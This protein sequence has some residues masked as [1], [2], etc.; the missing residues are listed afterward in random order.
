[1]R[2]DEARR[3]AARLLAGTDPAPAGF[4]WLV[5]AGPGEPDLLT[6]RAQR[7]LGEADVI[8]HDDAIPPALLSLGRRDARR[9]AVAGGAAAETGMLLAR[10]A[11]A[12]RC[13]V[14]LV[15]GDVPAA[16][17]TGAEAA[18]LRAA[19]IRFAVVPGIGV[20]AGAGERIAA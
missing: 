15:A 7:V 11:G 3:L 19:G 6:L 17:E 13:A 20:R 2:P 14:R 4:V 5:G 9:I 16:A 18:V 1:G 8:V 10:E 12:G